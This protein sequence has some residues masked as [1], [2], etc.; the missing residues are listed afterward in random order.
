MFCLIDF[1]NRW[2]RGYLQGAW[3][4]QKW[5][6]PQKSHHNSDGDSCSPTTLEF[7]LCSVQTACSLNISFSH[8]LTAQSLSCQAPFYTA[9]WEPSRMFYSFSPGHVTI[10]LPPEAQES[11]LSFQEQM[12]QFGGN[13]AIPRKCLTTVHKTTPTEIMKVCLSSQN[14]LNIYPLTPNCDGFIWLLWLLY[15][16]WVE[17]GKLECSNW[18]CRSHSRVYS[19]NE[20][21]EQSTFL[22]FPCGRIVESWFGSL[23]IYY[24][25]VSENQ[26]NHT[27]GA[28]LNTPSLQNYLYRSQ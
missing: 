7:S 9:E 12:I 13:V 20:H 19:G 10:C 4:T 15:F 17:H 23:S 5:L 2:L 3:I 25:I 27:Y 26:S 16:L 24:V 14:N 18:I 8:C 28:R 1:T 6:H 11:P 22:F 21:S